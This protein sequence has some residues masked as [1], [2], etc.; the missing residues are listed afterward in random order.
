M[1]IVGDNLHPLFQAF[2]FSKKYEEI[3][4]TNL[5]K[6]L[7]LFK[8][9][10]NCDKLSRLGVNKFANTFTAESII[11]LNLFMD[12][13]RVWNNLHI[14]MVILILTHHVNK[15]IS[16]E[17]LLSHHVEECSDLLVSNFRLDRG[18]FYARQNIWGNRLHFDIARHFH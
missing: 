6:S 8:P 12:Y 14:V 16:C 10:R 4:S 17:F 15:F 13:L 18:R 9:L 3:I 2:P 7:Y 11:V 5:I 1:F